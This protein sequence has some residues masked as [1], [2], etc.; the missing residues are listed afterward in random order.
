MKPDAILCADASRASVF[1][2]LL[3]RR[4]TNFGFPD[5]SV[6]PPMALSNCWLW[7]LE[8]NLSRC[9]PSFG[10]V[11]VRREWTM[12]KNSQPASLRQSLRAGQ[13]FALEALGRGA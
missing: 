13:L 2:G 12:L 7:A 10:R 3:R 1:A 5:G 8:P 9:K 11:R 4:P 6:T